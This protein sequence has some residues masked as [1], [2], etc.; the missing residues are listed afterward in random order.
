M[1]FY[2]A[3][4][5]VGGCTRVDEARDVGGDAPSDQRRRG[6]VLEGRDVTGI[7]RERTDG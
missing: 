2:G 7:F 6:F 4:H 3:R 1:W 5:G